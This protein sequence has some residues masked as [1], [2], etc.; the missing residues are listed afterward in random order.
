GQPLETAAPGWT[1]SDP[2]QHG[3]DSSHDRGPLTRDRV[4]GRILR[5]QPHLP[6]PA[7][8][9]LDRGLTVDQR[10]HDLTVF[11]GGL[12]PYRHPVAVADGRVDHR[13]ALD[14]EQKQGA[15]THQLPGQRID[16]L[17]HLL[18]QDRTTGGDL[19]E[20]RYE[21]RGR[22][23]A[24]PLLYQF[25]GRAYV[26]RSRPVGVPAQV[27]LALQY[28]ELVRHAGRRDQPDGLADL[29]HAG[30]VTVLFGP[31]PEELHD[32]PLAGR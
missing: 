18:G 5:Q 14:L 12:L 9:G 32:P 16:V 28:L 8:V 15:F 10:R 2:A 4:V 11:S 6:V 27:A 3:D 1:R 25:A 29:P 31:L 24:G 20:H 21:R 17:D 30:R 13:V 7:L 19:A 23:A 26:D 22:A